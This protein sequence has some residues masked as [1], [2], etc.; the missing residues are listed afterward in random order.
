MTH[1]PRGPMG[2][3]LVTFALALTILVAFGGLAVDAAGAWWTS[4]AQSDGLSVVRETIMSSENEIKFARMGTSS[5][6]TARQLVWDALQKGVVAMPEGGEVEAWVYEMPK[7]ATGA[8]DRVIGVRLEARGSYA[9]TFARSIGFRSVP[10]RNSITFLI[11]PY[12]STEVFRPGYSGDAEGKRSE[13]VVFRAAGDGRGGTAW[14][15]GAVSHP[16]LGSLPSELADAMRSATPGI[17]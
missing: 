12:S 2:Q 3:M 10:V 17:R 5:V 7:S 4:E 16:S 9:T 6:Y 1:E 14:S 15:V 11:Q 13:H 8:K